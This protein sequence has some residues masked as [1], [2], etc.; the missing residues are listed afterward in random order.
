MDKYDSWDKVQASMNK[1]RLEILMGVDVHNT[2]DLVFFRAKAHFEDAKVNIKKNNE[3]LCASA[4]TLFEWEKSLFAVFDA[5][6]NALNLCSP[7]ETKKE[8]LFE[9]LISARKQH[10]EYEQSKF[11]RDSFTKY[12]NILLSGW[13]EI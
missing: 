6:R 4:V 10:K 1:K 5:T 7:L 12:R 8:N 13:R 9:L 11:E 2:G 3:E